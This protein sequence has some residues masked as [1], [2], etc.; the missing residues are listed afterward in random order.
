MKK[1]LLFVF[2][3]A[4]ISSYSNV[5]NELPAYKNSENTI[6]ERVDDLINRMTLEEKVDLVGGNDFKSKGNKRLGIPEMIMTDGPL[7]P[8][9]KGHS[10][11][12]SAMINFA[13]TFNTELMLEVAKQMGEETRVMGR[14]MLLG[15]C[16]NIARAPHGGRTFEGYGEDP[17]LMSSFVVP[18]I[19]GV[20]SRR[21]ITCTKHFVA[22]NQ[23][24]N[25]FDVSAEIDERALREI[26]FPAFKAAVQ[27]AD[28][29]TIMAAY[30]RF[31]GTYACENKYLLQDVLK[32]EWGFTGTTVS[33]WG[34]ARS[35][36]PMA[37]SGLD[38]EMPN[39]KY[40]GEKLLKAINNGEVTEATLDDKVKRILS[41]MFKAGL[42]DESIDSYGGHSDNEY[43]RSLAKR[44]A[45]QSIIL[46]KNENNFLPL[47]SNK[48]KS[49]AVIGPNGGEARMEGGGSGGL[50]G[51]YG[52]SPYEGILNKVGDKVDVKFARG[53]PARSLDLPIAGP[54]FY[55]TKDGKPG[56]DAEYFNN[57]E[58]EGEPALTRVEKDINFN[59]EYSS[60]D[61][62]IIRLDKW[63]ARWTGKFKS[64]GDGWYEIGLRSDNGIRMYL[65][66]QKILDAWVD[67][68]PGKFKIARYKFEKDKWYD[69][70]VDFYENIGTCRCRLGFAP[71]K[72]GTM[73]EDAVKLA[74]KSDVVVL[75]MGLD[76]ELEGEAVD[77]AR[78]NLD[79]D[80]LELIKRVL[81][82]NKNVVMVLNNATPILMD[83]W[84][85]KTSAVIEAL[86]PGQE[87]GNSLADIIF[88][89]VNPSGKLPLT[90]PKKW[91]DT[92]IA[93]TYPGE[94][95]V[96]YY[97]EGIFVGYRHYDK[98]NI[99]P[100]FPFG[101]GL[102][103]TTF[104]YS[105]LK[106]SSEEITQ[107]DTLEISVMVKN[108][109]EK[110]GDEV[111]Q[112][113]ISDKAASVERE[114]KSL[115]GFKRVSLKAGESKEVTFKIDKSHLSFYDVDS[116]KWVAEP[117]EFEI[118]IGASSKDIRLK[119][120]FI[121]K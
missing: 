87:G 88:G 50:T 98:E 41:V 80:Q 121:L 105:D 8:N 16:I 81:A 53:I 77:R 57:K 60:P 69:L 30:N 59:W 4:I 17:Y 15:P 97:K 19:Q 48:I 114:V 5:S 32:N 29:W 37:N 93:N 100:L 55:M 49:I 92:P 63:S 35:T 62:N 85:D 70:K 10:T 11:N 40:Y 90:F 83:E 103:Y 78:L 43:R 47:N 26:Y 51:N 46:L 28:T 1:I 25:R 65:D 72:P 116:K 24:W 73:T 110:D 86:Y 31:R 99:E 91:E 18:Y 12:Y 68:R 94:K 95:E 66:G 113:Y 3:A 76:K 111:V 64:P 117:G 79:E 75:A 109:G 74:A 107:N 23:E 20:Q 118:L 67:A 21:V 7:G 52:I 61:T 45:D 39:G 106:L 56:L 104:E 42:F 36:V 22:N 6:E 119:E 2:V 13:A 89:D 102:S 96:A 14:N 112:L 34:G 38:L 27:E 9:T 115:K 58:V 101:F 54:E 84:L 44:V 33:D 71:Y 108:S 120:I 82:V